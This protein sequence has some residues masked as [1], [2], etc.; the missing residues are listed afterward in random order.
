MSVYK[1][2]KAG[3]WRKMSDRELKAVEERKRKMWLKFFRAYL[4]PKAKKW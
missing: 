2:T 3:K 4:I 1:M